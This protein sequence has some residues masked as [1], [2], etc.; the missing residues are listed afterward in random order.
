MAES[1][2][3]EFCPD[4][5]YSAPPMRR[6]FTAQNFIMRPSGW[7]L[8]PGDKNYSNFNRELELGEV[9]K[10]GAM[11]RYGPAPEEEE[12][13]P[14]APIRVPDAAMREIHELGRTIDRQVREEMSLPPAIL[15]LV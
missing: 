1:G 5:A 8:K 6:I 14:A 15:D 9:R 7:L 13:A 2:S 10:V 11:K 4:C 3:A 12:P